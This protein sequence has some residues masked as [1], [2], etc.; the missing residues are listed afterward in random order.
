MSGS[1]VATHALDW[2]ANSIPDQLASTQ[3]HLWVLDLS[4]VQESCLHRVLTDWEFQRAQ[5]VRSQPKRL[6]YLGGRLGL[7]VL[8]SRY[9]GI[10]NDNLRF[11]YGNKGKP[12]LLGQ[13]PSDEI[14][15]NYT[16]SGDKV[17]YGFSRRRQIGVDME[18]LPRKI[19]DTLMARRHLTEVERQ[20][21]SKL[22]QEQQHDAMICC[23]TR[24]EAYGK[25][26]GVGI[27]Y[28]LRQVALFTNVERCKWNT[29]CTGLFADAATDTS[30]AQLQGLQ[31]QGVQLQMPFAAA[32]AV[33]YGVEKNDY[34]SLRAAQL[35][36]K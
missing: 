31:L 14:T 20:T 15:F 12:I 30:A 28:H 10:E 7:R 22:A 1:A 35:I 13:K 33:M 25:T 5:R 36:I 32:A 11:G 6:L 2:S 17:L 27:R 9:S 8:L 29:V 34:P 24:K 21:W 4:E 19:N 3:I 23:W 18:V 26:L 16:L